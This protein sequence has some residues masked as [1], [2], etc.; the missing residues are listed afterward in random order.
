MI[1]LKASQLLHP[2][3]FGE[4]HTDY[5]NCVKL[6]KIFSRGDLQ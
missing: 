4:I 5:F 1:V 6:K 2:K 3:N